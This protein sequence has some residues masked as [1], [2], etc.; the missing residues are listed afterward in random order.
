MSD[1]PRCPKCKR[2][3]PVVWVKNPN[4]GYMHHCNN[5]GEDWLTKKPTFDETDRQPTEG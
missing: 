3:K 2:T 1:E 5:C 4:G